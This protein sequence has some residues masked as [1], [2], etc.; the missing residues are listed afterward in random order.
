[1]TIG[2]LIAKVGFEIK[3]HEKIELAEKSLEKMKSSLERLTTLELARTAYELAERFSDF[4][5]KIEVAAVSAGIS[6]EAFQKLSF[7]ASQNAVSTEEMSSAMAKL[8]RHLYDARKGSQEA[9]KVFADAGF[10]A[11]QVEGF[12]TGSDVMRALADRFKN[13]QDPIKKQAIAMELMGRGSVNMVGFLS[14]GSGALKQMGDEAERLGIVLSG[15]Q[16]EALVDVEHSL[17]KLWGTIKGFSATI[18]ATLA[19]SLSFII[20]QF[21]K[22]Y[23][24]NHKI[25][26]EGVETWAHRFA[27]T[28]GFLYGLIEDVVRVFLK[29]A[30]THRTLAKVVFGS[31]LAFTSFLSVAVAS[32]GVISALMTAHTNLKKSWIKAKQLWKLI[33][34]LREWSVV[35]RIA[36][37]ATWLWDAAMGAL[38]AEIGIIGA[39]V[40]AVVAAIAALVIAG[41]DLYAIFFN[42]ADFEDTWVGQAIEALKDA[43]SW[44]GDLFAKITGGLTGGA[45]DSLKG[46]VSNIIGGG[47]PDL[48]SST[49][50]LQQIQN[51]PAAAPGGPGNNSYEVNA[52]ITVNVPPGSDH[53]LVA[54]AAQD[55]VREHLDRVYRETSRS[56][57]PTVAY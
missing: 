6:V 50:F 48:V 43:A 33:G 52:P 10:S 13:I 5:E 57:R 18:A 49:N 39:P 34:L 26:Q 45:F 9:G 3:G 11:Q 53:K 12:K 36:A 28:M 24:A 47:A 22:F 37:G 25:V 30:D 29:F 14:K 40:W 46:A 17:Q 42:G 16:V 41:H 51:V 1:M 2:E 31:V 7:A 21:L 35:S 27:Y 8:S 54:Q 32:L 23:E 55:G 15:E 4:A 56:L 44:I 20:N 38:G 19:P